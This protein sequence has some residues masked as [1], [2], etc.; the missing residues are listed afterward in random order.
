MSHF[1]F[2]SP[3]KHRFA[4]HSH[5]LDK[6]TGAGVDRII[7]II[8][9][10][11]AETGSWTLIIVNVYS[12]GPVGITIAMACSKLWADRLLKDVQ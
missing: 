2:K 8:E 4:L 12:I 6:A 9:V 11:N 3:P 10:E 5:Q 7:V 1:G